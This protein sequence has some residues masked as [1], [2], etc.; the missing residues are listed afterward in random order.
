MEH[1]SSFLKC[2]LH[3]VTYMVGVGTGLGNNFTVEKPDLTLPQPGGQ[4]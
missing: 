3:I 1:N 4:D 2:E